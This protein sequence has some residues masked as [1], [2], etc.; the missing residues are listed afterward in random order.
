MCIDTDVIF[1]L[2]VRNLEEDATRVAITG[3]SDDLSSLV[4]SYLRVSV[5]W[6]E[7]ACLLQSREAER[8][9]DESG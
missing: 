1:D 7:I 2:I 4:F 6:H 9:L 8:K 3:G 5:N